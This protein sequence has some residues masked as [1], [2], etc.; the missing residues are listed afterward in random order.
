M[1]KIFNHTFNGVAITVGLAF[2]FFLAAVKRI[3]EKHD[4]DYFWE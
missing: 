1:K 2:V 3:E 4:N